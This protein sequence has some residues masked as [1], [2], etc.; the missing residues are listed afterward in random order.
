MSP[1]RAVL[2]LYGVSALLGGV[3]VAA[4]FGDLFS[5]L[6]FTALALLGAA[7]LG[8]VLGEVKIYRRVGSEDVSAEAEARPRELRLTL[9]NY[10]RPL[11]LIGADLV[12]VCVAYVAAYL[13]VYEGRIETYEAD[14]LVRSLPLVIVVRLLFLRLFGVYRGFW[15]YFS[16][17]DLVRLLWAVGTGSVAM[18]LTLVFLERFEGYSRFV[19]VVD[20]LLFF[21]FSAGLR[22][23]YKGLQRGFGWRT[24]AGPAALILGADD[25]GERCLRDLLARDDAARRV[26]GFLDRDRLKIGRTI[27][28]VP[29]LGDRDDLERVVGV[30]GVRELIVSDLAEADE[31]LR[32]KC[33][34]LGVAIR[35]HGLSPATEGA[36]VGGGGAGSGPGEPIQ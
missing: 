24:P 34:E 4:V 5:N 12:L 2:F 9:M 25:A 26:V 10:L 22:L 15:R 20:G 19:F 36:F 16:V 8:A 11:A 29:V 21:L 23:V 13:I 27:H 18:I 7:V 6:V 30:E 17:R 28:G 35:F 32:D 1:R 31:A 14:R 3:A 33:R